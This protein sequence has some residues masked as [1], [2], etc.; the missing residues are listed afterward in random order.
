[1]QG[2]DFAALASR[3]PVGTLGLDMTQEL[4]LISHKRT[5]IGAVE[6]LVIFL[7]VHRHQHPIP[8]IRKVRTTDTT[9]IHLFRTRKTFDRF[10]SFLHWFVHMQVLACA[11]QTQPG[12]IVAGRL[13]GMSLATEK[14]GTE[15]DRK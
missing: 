14:V 12:D 13:A 10:R 9:G 5:P 2:I 8:F 15:F 3:E 1:M 11:K 4:A 6:T 7:G